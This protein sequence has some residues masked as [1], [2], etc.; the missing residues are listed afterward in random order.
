MHLTVI[1]SN[2]IF[3]ANSLGYFILKFIFFN[4]LYEITLFVARSLCTPLDDAALGPVCASIVWWQRGGGRLEAL[5]ARLPTAG[6]GGGC[7]HQAGH[8]L[9]ESASTQSTAAYLYAHHTVSDA[10]KRV[11]AIGKLSHK[12]I[13]YI[14]IDLLVHFLT[15]TEDCSSY[16]FIILISCTEKQLFWNLL[17]ISQ[18]YFDQIWH[19]VTNI[20]ARRELNLCRKFKFSLLNKIQFSYQSRSKR[21]QWWSHVNKPKNCMNNFYDN[22]EVSIFSNW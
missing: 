22:L 18:T 16:L 1:F 17:H 5:A 13:F 21:N 4:P 3:T 7:G 9:H 8:V 6:A 20:V 19:M 10:L 2:L 12:W 11:T 14:Q 15:L